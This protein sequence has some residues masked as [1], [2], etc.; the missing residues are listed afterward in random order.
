MQELVFEETVRGGQCRA[1]VSTD[2]ADR[3]MDRVNR[4]SSAGRWNQLWV[5]GPTYVA[6]WS[7]FGSWA[8]ER[9]AR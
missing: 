6:P 8:G 5:A 3:S 1:T 2:E 9:S 4:D 7:D